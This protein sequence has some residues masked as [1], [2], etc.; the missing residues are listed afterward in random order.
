[1]S[2]DRY[3][4]T[5]SGFAASMSLA[6][7]TVGNTCWGAAAQV[8]WVSRSSDDEQSMREEESYTLVLMP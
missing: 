2:L 8:K 4:K 7:S 6:S 5:Q 1:M 3:L